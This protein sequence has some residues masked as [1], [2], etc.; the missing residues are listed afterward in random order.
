MPHFL[1]GHLDLPLF[2]YLSIKHLSKNLVK[3][4]LI[5]SLAFWELVKVAMNSIRHHLVDR[6]FSFNDFYSDMVQAHPISLIIR[7]NFGF[8]IQRSPVW[9]LSKAKLITVNLMVICH[10][11]WYR[12]HVGLVVG[13]LQRKW[14]SLVSYQ[15]SWLELTVYLWPKKMLK[16]A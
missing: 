10:H 12:S 1:A 4:A 2:L 11:K 7:E 16:S 8:T 15:E 9:S 14:W 5:F 3:R 13:H 6:L